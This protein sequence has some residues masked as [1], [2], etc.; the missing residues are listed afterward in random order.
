MQ[1]S[2]MDDPRYHAQPVDFVF[3][4]SR[5]DGDETEFTSKFNARRFACS[6]FDA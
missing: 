3:A 4:P 1:A 2:K 6:D 5:Y